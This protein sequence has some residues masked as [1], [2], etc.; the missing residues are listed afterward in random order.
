MSKKI[1]LPIYVNESEP[2]KPDYKWFFNMVGILIWFFLVSS[3]VFYLFAYFVIWNISLKKEKE[4]FWDLIVKNENIKKINKN[5]LSS[6]LKNFK[7]DL[8]IMDTNKVNA[9]ATLWG[10]IVLTKWLLEKIQYQEELLFVI[11]HEKNHLQNRDP[12]RVFL[13]IAPLKL[14]LYYIGQ[15]SWID[16]TKIWDILWTYFTKKIEMRADNWGIKFVREKTKSPWCMLKFF[17]QE[18]SPIKEYMRKVSSH[19]TIESRT[20]NIKNKLNIKKIDFEDC[21][22]FKYNKLNYR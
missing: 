17:E 8:H 13:T 1:D 21:N 20:N 6:K 4:I 5:Y 10:N 7:Y 11:W 3:F 14:T 16:I 9:F 12:L 18:N 19:P 22:K 15:E 2:S